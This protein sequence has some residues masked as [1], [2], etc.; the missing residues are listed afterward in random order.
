[1]QESACLR[2][3]LERAW[4]CWRLKHWAQRHAL[5]VSELDALRGVRGTAVE[6][7]DRLSALQKR[8]ELDAAHIAEVS[9]GLTAATAGVRALEERGS[10]LDSRLARA[11]TQLL[12]ALLRRR[13]SDALRRAFAQWSRTTRL[14]RERDAASQGRVLSAWRLRCHSQKSAGQREADA[15]RISALERSLERIT[16]AQCR[17]R[18]CGHALRVWRARAA[19]RKRLEEF[20]CAKS[21]RVLT[22]SFCVWRCRLSSS[23]ARRRALRWRVAALSRR[24]LAA[25]LRRWCDFASAERVERALRT[26]QT[27]LEESEKS[28]DVKLN[29][30]C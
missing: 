21:H 18:V 14:E 13:R 29:G 27:Q 26:K 1:M 12:A 15:D 20:S 24:M 19:T 28:N 17:A 30:T 2:S 5:A 25:A 9:D 8:S 4:R 16:A 23:R 10:A 11:K 7:T 3:S 22:Q 6:L